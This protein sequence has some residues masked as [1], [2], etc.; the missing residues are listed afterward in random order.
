MQ[1]AKVKKGEMRHGILKPLS[2]HASELQLISIKN[3]GHILE[4]MRIQT[5]RL[6]NYVRIN[7]KHCNINRNCICS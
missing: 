1:N 2:P 5:T 3:R 7:V 6:Q 4:Q